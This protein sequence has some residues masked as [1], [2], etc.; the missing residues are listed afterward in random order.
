MGEGNVLKGGVQT[1]AKPTALPAGDPAPSCSG[2][3]SFDPMDLARKIADMLYG[4]TGINEAIK[5]AP[6]IPPNSLEKPIE[7]V[8]PVAAKLQEGVVIYGE[9]YGP[10]NFTPQ[11]IAKNMVLGKAQK[12]GGML[13]KA[14]AKRVVAKMS[15]PEAEDSLGA[16]IK[17]ISD[18]VLS[19]ASLR[20]Q[21]LGPTP[22]KWSDTGKRVQARMQK[23]GILRPAGDPLNS[24]H[25]LPEILYKGRWYPVDKNVDMAHKI[26]A[27]TWWNKTGRF[28]GP[29][30]PYV[31]QFMAEADN[32]V[33][34]PGGGAGANRSAGVNLKQQYLPPRTP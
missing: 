12:I 14:G 13:L 16:F 34:M 10:R 33:L 22:G 17:K 25:A 20:D 4:K 9:L 29:R 31:R 26:D 18:R 28:Y 32:Y 15:T 21:Y 2:Q 11:N 3:A 5:N 1:N 23:E 8:R 30:S 27:V 7:A 24:Q 6:R 19:K